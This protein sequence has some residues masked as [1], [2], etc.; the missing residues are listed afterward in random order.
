MNNWKKWISQLLLTA[1]VLLLPLHANAET[2]T[3]HASIESVETLAVEA[4]DQ[5]PQISQTDAANWNLTLETLRMPGAYARF[6][7]TVV[8]DGTAALTLRESSRTDF[9]S[10]DLYL[11]VILDGGAQTLAPGERLTI[12]VEV[13]WDAA[14]TRNLEETEYGSF[15]LTLFCTGDEVS[16]GPAPS[17]DPADN[18]AKDPTGDPSDNPAKDP[19]GEPSDNPGNG[20]SSGHTDHHSSG[21]SKGHASDTSD[22][23]AVSNSAPRTGD[24]SQPV[25]WM[26]VFLISASALLL[27]GLLYRRKH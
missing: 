16:V 5:A 10:E 22:S 24:A 18:P 26:A 1:L 17:D 12:T 13:G 3:G 20:A 4:M 2:Q 27:A 7:V 9:P 21:G 14:S 8:N 11:N 6:Q 23:P 19:A 25:L 15:S